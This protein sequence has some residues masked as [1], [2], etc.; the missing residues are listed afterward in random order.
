MKPA[1]QLLVKR[2]AWVLVI[3]LVSRRNFSLAPI[4]LTTRTTSA[5]FLARRWR[6]KG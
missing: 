5:T 6:L 1:D 2:L 4:G 3:K